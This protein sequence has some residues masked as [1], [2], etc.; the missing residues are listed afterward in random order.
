MKKA[1]GITA[2]VIVIA[3]AGWLG[4]TW[5]TGKR[6]EAEAPAQLTQLNEELAKIL[7]HTGFGVAVEQMSYERHF[8][9]S[10]VRYGIK[11]TAVPGD[12][13]PPKQRVEI[14][15]H[16]EHGP[17]AKSALARGQWAP[18]LAFIHSEVASTDDL[19]PVFELTKGVSPLVAE[20]VVSYNGDTD[21][22]A[23]IAPF[24]F[25]KDGQSVK[26][27]GAT[28]E[29]KYLRAT[30]QSIGTVNVA[31]LA[32]RALE[33]EELVNAQLNGI[34][35][36]I[37]TRMG[38]FDFSIGK[39]SAKIDTV[40]IEVQQQT[41]DAATAAGDQPAQENADPSASTEP[42]AE[43]SAEPGTGQGTE[44]GTEQSTEQGIEDQAS[45]AGDKT[46]I[47]LKDLGYTVDLTESGPNLAI[48]AGYQIGNIMVNGSDFGKGNATIKADKIDGKAAS[49]LSKIYNEMLNDIA[50]QKAE[51]ADSAKADARF[52]EVTNQVIQLL[53][54]DPTLRV[55]PFVWQTAKGESNLKLAIDL[56][57]PDSLV[58]GQELPSNYEQLLQEAIK[59]IDLKVNVSKPMLQDLATRYMERQGIEATMAAEQAA[60]Q[61]N[62]MTA[63]AEMFGI[64]KVEDANIVTTFH[65]ADRKAQLNGEEIPADELF[66]TLLGSVADAA[67]DAEEENT[68]LSTLDPSNIAATIEEAGYA[69]ELVTAE[70]GSPVLK[71]QGLESE[72]DSAEIVFGECED[73]S[74]CGDMHMKIT[75]KT[76]SP[77]PLEVLNNWNYREGTGRAYLDDERNAIYDV[78]VSAHGGIGATKVRTLVYIFMSSLASFS[79]QVRGG[80]AQ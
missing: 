42:G 71:I 3:V 16:V 48:T 39:S 35:M 14:V 6:I 76:P 65:Y 19:K 55:D 13:E 43:Q 23:T 5:Y 53:A 79:E 40:N 66:G 4:T 17:F 80:V 10:D 52:I 7:G 9:N 1:V 69:Y 26:F 51:E 21:G 59:L 37:D 57:K 29:G 62:S 30:K 50:E 15:A 34:S 74:S 49:A 77:V 67:G 25:T 70:N 47:E 24:E 44:Q 61:I 68:L 22:S 78:Y 72:A 56:T 63:M 45:A 31:Q 33:D 8:F 36:D 12:E 2:G 58:P 11:L 73:E 18:K 28:S 54:A 38:Q 75:V 27:S 46:R 32:I 64:A 60:D 20:T 41:T